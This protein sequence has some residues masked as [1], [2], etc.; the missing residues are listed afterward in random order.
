MTKTWRDPAY[1]AHLQEAI[2]KIHHHLAGKGDSDFRDD[3]LLQDGRIRNREIIGEAVTKLSSELKSAQDDIPY[4][5]PTAVT[6]R[7]VNESSA[8]R[9]FETRG[10]ISSILL[11]LAWSTTTASGRLARF[12]SCAR[13]WSLVTDASKP[14]DAA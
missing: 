6:E 5:H 13:P 10:R 2:Q 1:W 9:S 7:G 12:C 11:V 3:V 14:F 4:P 8:Q